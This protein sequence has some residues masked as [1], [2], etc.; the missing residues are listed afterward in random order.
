MFS[1]ALTMKLKPGCLEG[2]REAHRHLW[3]EIARSMD[4]HQV[5]MVI[6]HHDGRLFLFA[7]APSERHWERSR[8][9]PR[10][11]DWDAAMTR[12]L[13]TDGPG[14]IRFEPLERLFVWGD[15]ARASGAI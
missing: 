10:L 4:E 15:F 7:S 5:S 1:I 2:Y 13:E 6:G 11:K 12:F 9:E 8:Q 3:P 14:R